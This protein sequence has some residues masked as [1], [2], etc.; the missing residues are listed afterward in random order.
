MANLFSRIFKLGQAEAHNLV[1]KL[2]DP[3]K[4]TEQ[5]IR[6]LKADLQKA[7]EA[8]AQVKAQSLRL[9]K[10]SENSR[11]RAED[12]ERKAMALLQ[13]VSKGE[14]DATEGDRL[15]TMA[16]EKKET[17]SKHASDYFSQ[18]KAQDASVQKLEKKIT[19]LKNQIRT[20]E[21]DLTVLKARA[22]TAQA[23]KNINKQLSNID[24][25]STVSM[26]ERMKEKVEADEY[27]AEAYAE[28]ADIVMDEDEIEKALNEA[29]QKASD[30]LAALKAKMG[31]Q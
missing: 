12:N 20:Y 10:E 8:L 22:K 29:P 17:D 4:L 21:N 19:Y 7:L 18:Y 2:E 26:L 3:I 14:L 24:S 30:D 23:T 27:L 1:D 9:K 31:M 13:K 15:A 6:D 25:G 11:K 16:L 28:S 5:G